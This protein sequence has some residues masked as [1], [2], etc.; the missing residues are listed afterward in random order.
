MVVFNAAFQYIF[1]WRWD[2]V[3][4]ILVSDVGELMTF[5]GDRKATCLENHVLCS[6]SFYSF[7]KT[8]GAE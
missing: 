6:G 5:R 8:L 1:Y 2:L 4:F 3:S 7:G